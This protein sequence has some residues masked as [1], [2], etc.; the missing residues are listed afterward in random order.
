MTRL[1][2]GAGAAGTF[3]TASGAALRWAPLVILGLG[4]LALLGGALA[5]VAASPRIALE[6][7]VEPPRVEKGQPAIA[8]IRATNLSWRTVSGLVVEQRLGET[9][10][11]AELPR[12]QRGEVGARTYRLPTSRRG[13]Y[14]VGPVEVP[15]ADPFGLCRRVRALGEP[16][17]I[18]VHPRSLPLRP[19]PSGMSR[20]LEGPSSDMSPQGTVSFH[21]LREY[22]L[23]DDLRT[24]HWPSTARVGK[25]VV[26]HYVDTAQPYTVVL[27]DLNPEVYSYESFE[28]A[29][30]V[31]A[32]VSTSMS[33]GRAPVQLRTTAGDRVGAP[34]QRDATSLV[35]YL[36]DLAPC[37]AGSLP[38][39]L[40]PLR[41][42]QGGSAL[43]VITGTLALDSLPAI[44]SLSR[45]FDH[46]IVASLVPR[47]TPA[48]NYPGVNVLVATTAAELAQAW[49]NLAVR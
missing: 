36:T 24:V 44:A 1:G 19:L 35:D 29:M 25:L 40:A 6:R 5:Y 33:V 34:G 28:E 39:Q 48:P 13:T 15:K 42:A 2:W 23:G 11:R 30:D 8:V 43:V 47:P 46:V 16:Q 3:L 37:S 10:F 32:S 26:R 7:A 20:N 9:V 17:V 38:A 12:L 49:D 45:H 4:L 14:R 31:A 18:S 22:V 21:R 41:R 27:V